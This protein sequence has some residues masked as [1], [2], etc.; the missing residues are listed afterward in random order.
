MTETEDI[1]RALE[2]FSRGEQPDRPSIKLLHERGYI[3]V[4]D[5]TNMQSHE[6]EYLAIS[7]TKNGRELLEL[8][9]KK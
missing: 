7:I 3:T 9:K 1:I 4:S 6:R 2:A 5:V 8:W